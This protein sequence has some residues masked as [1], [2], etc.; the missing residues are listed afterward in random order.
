LTEEMHVGVL[1]ERARRQL[2]Q[3]A[4]VG[5]TENF[6]ESV[7]LLCDLLGVPLPRNLPADNVGR[8]RASGLRAS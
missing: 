4:V 7:E 2:E 1:A 3:M 6:T 5:I 8:Q